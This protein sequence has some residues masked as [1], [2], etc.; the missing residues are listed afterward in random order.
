[1]LVLTRRIGESL[2]IGDDIT[3][4]ILGVGNMQVRVGIAA[5]RETSIH[6][7]EVYLRRTP[8]ALRKRREEA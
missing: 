4:T 7:E 5:P 1:M 2:K 6:R 8:Q 3:L